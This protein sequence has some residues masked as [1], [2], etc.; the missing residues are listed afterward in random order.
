M[1][2]FLLT[3]LGVWGTMHLYVLLRVWGYV[4][5]PA[6]WLGLLALVGLALMLSPIGGVALAHAGHVGVGRPLAWFGMLWTG[7]FFLFFSVSLLHD[8]YNG[9]LTALHYAVPAL[10]GVRLLGTWP[11]VG[12]A[13]LVGVLTVYGVFEASRIRVE[14]VQVPT[15]E[16]PA[17]VQRIRV[18][19]IS[20]V[21]LG[22]IVGHRR[23]ERIL[24][25]VR[26]AGPD[27]IVSTGDLV[28]AEMSGLDEL[29][30][31][32]AAVEAPR[33]KFAITGNHEYYAGLDQALQFT[34]R[35][36]FTVL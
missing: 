3:V 29:G 5:F 30:S 28:D 13:I 10:S 15:D 2:G 27:I 7:A 1:I 33:G 9:L 24:E 19:Q 18:A 22:L 36:G 35:A 20:D 31:V 23:L 26:D 4:G 6:R 8:A 14:H 12:E 17:G 32:L 16:L 25:L 11:I 34:R 21:H